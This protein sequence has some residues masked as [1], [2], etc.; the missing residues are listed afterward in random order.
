MKKKA[1]KKSKRVV[2]LKHPK[3]LQVRITT[4]LFN[5]ITMNA[6]AE[7]VTK[8]TFVRSLLEGL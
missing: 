1:K 7:R 2:P 5:W 6:R 3:A 8:S 4:K